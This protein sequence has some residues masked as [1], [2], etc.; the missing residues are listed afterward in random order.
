MQFQNDMAL[1]LRYGKSEENN[2]QY[3]HSLLHKLV[4]V[5]SHALPPALTEDG[6]FVNAFIKYDVEGNRFVPLSHFE[7]TK[8]PC[9][10]V[11]YLSWKDRTLPVS[12]RFF[13]VLFSLKLLH[14]YN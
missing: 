4:P 8:V 12:I 10:A 7:E 3:F 9:L 13:L 11:I 6:I 1:N 14:L 2:I 5:N